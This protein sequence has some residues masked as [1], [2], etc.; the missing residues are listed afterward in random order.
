[1]LTRAVVY[2]ESVSAYEGL[3]ASASELAGEVI[4]VVVGDAAAA[5]QVSELGVDVRHVPY[6]G[7][8]LLDEYW[9]VVADVIA[10]EDAGLVLLSAT[11]R[12]RALAGLLAVKLEAEVAS[13]PTTL[14]ATDNGLEYEL[15]RYGGATVQKTSTT[16]PLIAVLGPEFRSLR[17]RGMEEVDVESRSLRSKAD[18]VGSCVSKGGPGPVTLIDAAI[19]QNGVRLVSRSPKT[20]QSVDLTAATVVIGVGRGI[21]SEENVEV[22]A[23]V[24]R[25][26]GA[27]LACS[28]PI[29]EGVGWLPK[30][31]Y[32]GVSGAVIQPD[33]YLAL[34]ISGQVQH[35]MGVNGAQTIVAINK[36]KSA[37][38]FAHCDLG[39]IADLS[40]ILPSLAAE[41]V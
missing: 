3:C 29:A 11:K 21:G 24:A 13:D 16:A 28:R 34:G 14:E 20:E 36:D 19:P 31:R 5:A 18:G 32:L 38:I 4:A 30:S 26:I 35:M 23:G 7:T 37:P 2:G 33:L 15:V 12:V 25:S 41:L 8:G 6:D 27:E 1:M 22:A 10:S 9:P 40:A 39:L 17:S